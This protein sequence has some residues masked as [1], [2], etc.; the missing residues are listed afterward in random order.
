[1]LE[2][3]LREYHE[4]VLRVRRKTL[5]KSGRSTKSTE[6]HKMIMEAIK[7]GD[8]DLAEKTA[9]DHVINAYENMVKNGLYEAYP[10]DEKRN[11]DKNGQ[12]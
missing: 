2:N 3:Q 10:S 5:S 8:R 6:E 9:N 7:S 1:M 12:D 4:Y 11:G